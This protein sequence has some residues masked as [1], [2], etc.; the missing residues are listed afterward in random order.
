MCNTC[1]VTGAWVLRLCVCLLCITE[2][3][4]WGCASVTM[5][6]KEEVVLSTT[7]DITCAAVCVD[8]LECGQC[9]YHLQTLLVYVSTLSQCA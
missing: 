8:G 1:C 9:C 3:V 2:S 6:C 4:V 5:C 7:S